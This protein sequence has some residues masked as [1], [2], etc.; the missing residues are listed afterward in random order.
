MDSL[1]RRRLIVIGSAAIAVFILVVAGGFFGSYFLALSALH[2]HNDLS[3][4]QGCTH[5]GLIYAATEGGEMAAL[6]AAVGQ[7]LAQLGCAR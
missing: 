4:Q 6:H 5:W 2:N 1:R 7:V 3:V